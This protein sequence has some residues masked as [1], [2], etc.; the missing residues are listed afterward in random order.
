MLPSLP[1]LGSVIL[2]GHS[3]S[4]NVIWVKEMNMISIGL[5]TLLKV[6]SIPQSFK[7]WQVVCLP[8]A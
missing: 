8:T 4:L 3:M 1:G 7:I 5:L 2:K 6:P